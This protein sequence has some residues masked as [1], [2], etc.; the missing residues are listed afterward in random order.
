M[1]SSVLV[2]GHPRV[3]DIKLL[4][5]ELDQAS[6]VQATAHLAVDHVPISYRSILRCGHAGVAPRNA[7]VTVD[8]VG[9]SVKGVGSD[10]LGL[11]PHKSSHASPHSG[12]GIVQQAHS[13]AGGPGERG[14]LSGLSNGSQASGLLRGVTSVGEHSAVIN[15]T[16]IEAVHRLLK[17][18]EHAP[19]HTICTGARSPEV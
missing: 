15:K 17:R 11:G 3:V 18:A 6:F 13:A 4:S 14:S 1:S 19:H 9:C 7:S 8:C 10:G 12:D 2:S 5:V 16:I